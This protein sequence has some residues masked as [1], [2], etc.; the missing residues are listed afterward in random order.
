MG[1]NTILTCITNPM[2]WHRPGK[3]LRNRIK[4]QTISKD[5][6]SQHMTSNVLNCEPSIMRDGLLSQELFRGTMWWDHQLQFQ[7]KGKADSGPVELQLPH[8]LYHCQ[9]PPT[10]HI[11][12][13]Q[14]RPASGARA[15]EEQRKV[16]RGLA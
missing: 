12:G 13:V 10:P 5:A 7:V 2:G 6:L 1:R 9:N 4:S 8:P 14:H 16:K 11:E 3:G 15:Q